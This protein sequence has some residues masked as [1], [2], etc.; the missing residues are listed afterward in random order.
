MHRIQ[1]DS[2]QSL[3]QEMRLLGHLEAGGYST[4]ITRCRL[5]MVRLHA[6][7]G[8]YEEALRVLGTHRRQRSQHELTERLLRCRVA[9]VERQAERRRQQA[10]EINAHS[11][12]LAVIGRLIA[13]TH[14]ALNAPLSLAHQ[15][16]AAPPGNPQ[17]LQQRMVDVNRCIDRATVLVTQLKLFSYRAVPQQMALSLRDALHEAQQG[18]LAQGHGT[19]LV[20]GFAGDAQ[21]LAWADPQRLG[22]LLK[23][24]L[25]ELMQRFGNAPVLADVQVLPDGQIAL[26]VHTQTCAPAPAPLPAPRDGADQPTSMSL[27]L[28]LCGEIALE[29][30]GSLQMHNGYEQATEGLVCCLRLP[31][32]P[33]PAR[34]AAASAVQVATP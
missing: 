33:G 12:R 28:S 13:H 18:L 29:M 14:H 2:M 15:C 31:G 10:R 17:E 5:R 27:G 24:L 9:A 32:G 23:V 34:S 4:E 1:G 8:R 16:L 20:V 22:I 21:L 3:R 11:A 6:L 25:L 30:G 7:Q 19:E 26:S